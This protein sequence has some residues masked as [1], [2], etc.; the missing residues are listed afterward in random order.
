MS[1]VTVVIIVIALFFIKKFLNKDKAQSTLTQI[2][3]EHNINKYIH[4]VYIKRIDKIT[5]TITAVH[6]KRVI[7]TQTFK[8]SHLDIQ[9]YILMFLEKTLRHHIVP[10]TS[11]RYHRLTNYKWNVGLK[12][13]RPRN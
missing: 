12:S 6:E 7:N 4:K 1:P 13:F 9:F 10:Y 8:L 2:L 5:Y 3:K 11:V